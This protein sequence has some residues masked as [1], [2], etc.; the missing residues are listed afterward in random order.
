[1]HASNTP[2]AH[3]GELFSLQRITPE[4]EQRI[5]AVN[6]AAHQL[7]IA[8]TDN[9]PGCADQSAALRALRELTL[10]SKNAIELD[11]HQASE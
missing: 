2:A 4:K 11:L 9:V 6:A 5:K 1:M 7:A 3:L 10:V 8:I